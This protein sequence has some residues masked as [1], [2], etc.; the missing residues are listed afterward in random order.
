[1]FFVRP[2]VILRVHGLPQPILSRTCRF[3]VLLENM[4]RILCSATMVPELKAYRQSSS[5]KLTTEAVNDG[6]FVEII[7]AKRSS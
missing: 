6:A 7:P 1:M 3:G 2:Y 4:K 5:V